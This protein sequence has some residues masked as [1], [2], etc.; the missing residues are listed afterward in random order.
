MSFPVFRLSLACLATLSV[1]SFAADLQ[2]DD[3]M[4]TAR[5]Y[6]SDSFDTP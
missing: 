2:L 4:I 1:P 6:A 3:S 5:G